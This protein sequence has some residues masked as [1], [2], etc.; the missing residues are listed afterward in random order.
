M[1]IDLILLISMTIAMIFAVIRSSLL[2]SAI[3]LAFGSA[4]LSVLM[5]RLSSPIA[6]VFELSVCVGLITVIFVSVIALTRTLSPE[7]EDQKK[8]ERIRRFW[9]L[10]VLVIISAIVLY[11]VNFGINFQLPDVPQNLSL[12]NLMWDIRQ[13]DMIGQVIILLTG[14]FAVAVLYKNGKKKNKE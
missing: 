14:V 11:Y 13:T 6:A 7:E 2:L 10:P 8:K 3:S 1:T 5:F 4:I 12:R 9:L